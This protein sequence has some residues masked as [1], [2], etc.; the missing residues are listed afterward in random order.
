MAIPDR[1]KIKDDV[2]CLLALG[3]RT[4][5]SVYETLATSWQLS[6][7]E[8]KLSRSGGLLYKHEIRW[9]R[10]ELKIEGLIAPTSRF[11]KGVWGLAVWQAPEPIY[12]ANASAELH[13]G[14]MRRTMINSYERNRKARDIC[15]Q[16]HGY[17]CVIC[18]ISMEAKYGKLGK[19]GIHVHHL[20]ELSSVSSDY[21]VDPI[22]DLVPVCPNCH[23]IIHRRQPAYQIEEVARMMSS[24]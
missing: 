13:E 3:P 7:A 10:Q 22:K 16:H 19:E 23:Y 4:I 12:G 2:L 5:N 11:G 24:E 17:N 6:D 1:V 14:A 8:M 20:V 21:I 9:A 18:N 15:L